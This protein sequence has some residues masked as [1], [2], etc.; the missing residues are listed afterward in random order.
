VE[1]ATAHGAKVF[2]QPLESFGAQ[3]QFAVDHATGD[4]I[5]SIDADE[6][7]TPELAR[8]IQTAIAAP[9][10]D[11]Y[12]VIR[13]MYF[14][15]RRLRYGGVGTDRILRLFR[16]GRGH[17]RNVSVHESIQVEGAVATL[18][19]PLEHYSYATLDE[20]LAKCDHYTTLAA[21][22]RFEEGKRFHWTAH[23]RPAWELFMRVIL[24][25]AWLDGQ[26]GLLYAALSA[27]AAW[28]REI[29][30]WELEHSK[31]VTEFISRS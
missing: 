23:L 28:L 19:A 4:W 12:I 11:G 21:E 18:T 24:K 10:A 1:I 13:R 17:F 27:H 9:K 6:R 3:K 22:A 16:S 25:G 7:V 8:E 15:G 14:L 30:L 5:F 2:S 29:K 31:P 26:A 20:Y